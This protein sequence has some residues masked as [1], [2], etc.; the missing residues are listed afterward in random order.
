MWYYGGS[1]GHRA[2]I[3]H[4]PIYAIGLAHL[5]QRGVAFLSPWVFRAV[6]MP[7]VAL[8]LFQTVQYVE[9]IIPFDNMNRTKYWN[10]FLQ[11]GDDLAW[12]YSPYAGQDAYVAIDSVVIRHD[13]E[14]P[15]GWGNEQQLTGEEFHTGRQAARMTPEDQYGITLRTQAKDVSVKANTVRMKAWVKT[16]KC[17]TDLSMVCSLEDSTGA[18]YYWRKHP[19]RPQL[20]GKN[21]WSEVTALFKAGE[22]RQPSDKYV[23]YLMK[24]DRATVVVDE[25]E[26]SLI[27]AR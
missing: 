2:F 3:D 22:A 17:S 9:H 10:L 18:G 8:Q 6:L 5:L 11:R 25:L 20:K 16:D 15:W 26:I 21:E 23:I 27:H 1:F 7:L 12:Y 4:Y 13:M 24:S 19:L 14:Q